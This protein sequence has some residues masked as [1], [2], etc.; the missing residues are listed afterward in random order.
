MGALSGKTALALAAAVLAISCGDLGPENGRVAVVFAPSFA[1]MG[2]VADNPALRVDNI[3]IVL[4]GADGD[5]LVD[6]VVE[7]PLEQD[8]LRAEIV[9]EVAGTETFSYRI[10]GREG[11]TVLFTA[12]PFEVV[13]T[14]GSEEPVVVQPLLV[15]AGPETSLVALAI[16]DAPAS[17]A[18]G[19]AVDLGISGT[20]DIGGTVPDPLVSWVSLDTAVATVDDEG[21]VTARSV[22]SRS[23]RI[24][25]R[26]AFSALADTVEIAVD[27]SAVS[28]EAGRDTVN[29]LGFTVR[30]VATATDASGAP[31]RAE[32]AWTSRDEAVVRVAET[33]GDTAVLVGVSTGTAWVVAGSGPAADS[34]EIAVRQVVS[35]VALLPTRVFFAIGDTLRLTG[36]AV[37][38]GGSVVPAAALTWSSGSAAA[39]TSSRP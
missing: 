2:A 39:C 29:A 3:R 21:V 34:V 20:D 19:A 35:A 6:Q 1:E 38:S 10:E 36:I 33:R 17:L 23:A 8:T 26:V 27:P 14:G 5:T 4:T 12:G 25:A 13:L 31:V 32:Y 11:V 16:L 30:R 24:V 28:I 9:V 37:D 22:A 18:A 15:Y 7:W